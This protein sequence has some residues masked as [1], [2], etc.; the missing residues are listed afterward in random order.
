M[1]KKTKK[2]KRKKYKTSTKILKTGYDEQGR[3]RGEV[4]KKMEKLTENKSAKERRIARHIAI[5]PGCPLCSRLR[6]RS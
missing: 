6:K 2:R 4:R 1:A 3:A 5:C